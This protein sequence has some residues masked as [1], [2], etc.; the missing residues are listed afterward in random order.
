[1][2]LISPVQKLIPLKVSATESVEKEEPVEEPQIRTFLDEDV[3]ETIKVINQRWKRY[4]HFDT[5]F[6]EHVNF[7][8]LLITQ[9]IRGGE[10][11]LKYGCM[12]GNLISNCFSDL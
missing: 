9:R 5:F 6:D 4:E 1:M 8:P 2:K 7:F 11:E 12:Q 3:H 10:C